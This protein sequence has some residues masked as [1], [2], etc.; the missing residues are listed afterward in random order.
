M[1]TLSKPKPGKI[2]PIR[3]KSLENDLRALLKDERSFDIS[4]KCSDGVTLRACKNILSTRSDVFNE[5]IFNKSKEEIKNIKFNKISSEVM[6]VIL[7]F[8]YTSNVKKVDLTI[9]DFVEMYY[10]ANCFKLNELQKDI[11]EFSKK[12]LEDGN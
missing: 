1:T 5:L 3:G 12:I 2:T 8:L 9:K 7:E 11:I 4:L 6:K 10:A